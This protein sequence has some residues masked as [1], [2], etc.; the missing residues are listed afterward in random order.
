MGYA[1]A[2]FEVVGVDINPQP[3]YPFEF[4][5]ADA[6]TYPF[7]GFDVVHAS[8]P[9]QRWCEA[10]TSRRLGWEHPDLLGPTRE[11]LVAWGGL[12][13]IE[14]VP[15]APMPTSFVLCGATFDLPIIRHRRFEV[16]P[17]IAL[18]PSRCVQRNF[19][20]AV[21]HGPGF[22]PYA[23]KS[24]ERAWREHVLPVV[25]PWMTLKEAG[26]AIPPAYTE[27]IG[28]QLLAHVALAEAA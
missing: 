2:G 24:W 28:K 12:Y 1:R 23:R 8:P 11:R 7:D 21:S 10:G 6:M 19:N 20:R 3:N 4:H 15:T 16:Y 9:C 26:Q 14:N 5:Q 18:P 17:T 27:Y 22:H 13:V 25:W